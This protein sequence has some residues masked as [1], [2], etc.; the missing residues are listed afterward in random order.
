MSIGNNG[1]FYI[2]T[3]NGDYYSKIAGNWVLKG[4]VRGPAGPQGVQ[5]NTGAT[6]ATGDPGA[7]VITADL[8]FGNG[9]PSNGLGID[10]Q[11]YVDQT[12]TLSL[13]AR[14]GYPGAMVLSTT[15]QV[16]AANTAHIFPLSIDRPMW[17]DSA[18]LVSV[19]ARTTGGFRFLVY[20]ATMTDGKFQ[21][22]G[23]P[24]YS[25]TKN[26]TFLAT[27][28]NAFVST[29]L[30]FV[31]EPGLYAIVLALDAG[32]GAQSQIAM[33]NCIFEGSM[34]PATTTTYNAIFWEQVNSVDWTVTAADPF[35]GTLASAG[36][37]LL[38]NNTFGALNPVPFQLVWWYI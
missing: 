31:L 16:L 12:G 9:V 34:V 28:A 24:V 19:I 2:D 30:G 11:V 38:A 1:D 17:I 7:V 21:P 14:A 10:S 35:T 27:A 4:N 32:S 13:V 8:L 6:G 3:L 20:R 22:Y 37:Q 18:K 23:S 29:T 26:T 36:S 15:T 25:G 5:G 33:L